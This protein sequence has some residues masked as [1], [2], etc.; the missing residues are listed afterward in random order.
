MKPHIY[1]DGHPFPDFIYGG[2]AGDFA[3]LYSKYI[4]P[5]KVFLY[6]SFLCALGSIL[7]GKLFIKS[8]RR[9]ET[10]FYL[11]L[12]GES[13]NDRKSTAID[14]VTLFFKEFFINEDA[15]SVLNTCS[16]IGSAEGLQKRIKETKN[17]SLL[18]CID[19][20]RALIGKCKIEGSILLPCLNTLFE[21][22]TY[23]GHTKNSH[24]K[25]ENA[26]LSILSASTVQTYE[27]IWTSHFIDM[28]WPNRIFIVIGTGERTH[29]I[30][31]KIP[32]KKKQELAGRIAK[33]LK[34]VGDGLE[35]VLTPE[36]N[37]E[38]SNWYLKLNDEKSVHI[39]RLDTYALRFMPLLAVNEEKSVIDLDIVKKTIAL[40]NW[41]KEIR[42]TY[43]PIDCNNA[44]A[45]IEEKIRRNLKKRPR[46]LFDLKRQLHVNKD[47]LWAFTMAMRN[48][49]EGKFSRE[50]HF[51]S[52]IKKW[53]LDE[54]PY[55]E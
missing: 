16:G 14:V 18:L 42:E 49:S 35:M 11:L 36:A 3:N 32:K 27:A 4:E 44:V 24:I 51:D 31:R 34:S 1:P 12:L 21:D 52:G 48:L 26:R 19:E 28:G 5:P 47:G 37:K 40:M 23:E 22:N 10:R 43:D 13:A 9:F 15:S 20:Y 54:E 53:M 25:L 30:P 38:Y 41:Q 50:I 2:I 7:A 45:G 29:P 17:S 6:H 55:E 8:E 46:T 39:K 33:I